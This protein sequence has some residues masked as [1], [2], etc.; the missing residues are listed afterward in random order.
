MDDNLR[1]L[2]S[3]LGDD[4]VDCIDEWSDSMA[5]PPIKW[6]DTNKCKQLLSI[7]HFYLRFCSSLRIDN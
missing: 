1:R 5:T 6:S 3:L 4:K 2:T 7:A